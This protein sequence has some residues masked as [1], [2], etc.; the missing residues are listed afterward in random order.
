[1]TMTPSQLLH[2][3]IYY[4]RTMYNLPYFKEKDEATVIA[5]MREHPFAFLCGVDTS[6]KPVVTQVPFFIDERE[7][8]I[9]LTGHI[10]RNSDHHKAFVANPHVL[11]VFTS[12]SIYVSATWYDDPH[13]A[14]T[15]N[16]MSVHAKGTIS[17]GNDHDLE[18]ILRRLTLHYEDGNTASTTIFDNL[19]ES[20][21]Q[22][23]MKAI[24]AFEVKVTELENVFKLS[25]NKNEKTYQNI[26]ERLEA[27]DYNGRFIAEQ[28]KKRKAQLFNK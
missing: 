14:S 7:G 5:F 28:M 9:Y 26:I 15:W 20:Y 6:N 17:F 24:V 27:K 2:L 12:P 16:Y 11:S 21:R 3:P 4:F 1:M 19:T 18:N 10:M 13:E 22:R 23:L 25:Q 8:V